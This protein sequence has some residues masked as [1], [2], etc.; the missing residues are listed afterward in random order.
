MEIQPLDL[1]V[2]AVIGGAML[3]GFF[4]GFVKEGFSIA[5]LGGA[6]LAVQLF[7]WPTAD[8]LQDFSGNDIGPSV[9]PWVAGACLAVGTIIAVVLLGRGLRR[10][11]R[12]AG[13]NWADRAGGGLLGATEGILIAG[14]IIALG[15][16]VLGRDHPAFSNTLSLAALE[17]FERIAEES[18]IEIDVAS[19]PGTF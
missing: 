11:L 18:E 6:Y 8:W 17:E 12:M 16:E 14:F 4:V 9:A 1:V 19:P 13:L 2:A 5:A 15:S 7:T 10:T 3:R